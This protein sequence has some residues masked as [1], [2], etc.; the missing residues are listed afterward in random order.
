MGIGV[1]FIL[2]GWALIFEAFGAQ[3]LLGCYC[4]IAM[5]LLMSR[6]LNVKNIH[7]SPPLYLQMPQNMLPFQHTNRLVKYIFRI[8]GN[9]IL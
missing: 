4:V 6:K 1:G 2:A 8:Y 3:G 7:F 5:T 9:G